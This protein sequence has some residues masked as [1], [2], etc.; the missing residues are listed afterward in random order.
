LFELT[1]IARAEAIGNQF[2]KYAAL[3][4]AAVSAAGSIRMS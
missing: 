3:R 2:K 4:N 1:D